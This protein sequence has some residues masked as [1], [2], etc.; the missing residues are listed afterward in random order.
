MKRSTRGTVIAGA[1]CLAS[2]IAA[3]TPLPDP[4]FDAAEGGFVPPD[5]D[6]YKQEVAVGKLL[7]KYAL[8]K[9]KCDQKAVI[10]LQLAYEPPG[11][12]KVPDVQA[13][14][15]ECQ[16]KV[17]LK[18]EVA[19]DKLLLKG[20]PACLNQAG[21]DAIK[22][23]LDTQ[24][25][26]LGA[27]VYCDG[28]AIAPDPETGLNIPDFKNEAVGEVA[29]AKV[30]TKVGRYGG[31]CYTLALKYAF[32][33][34]GVLPPD[35]LA[36]VDACFDKASLKGLEDMAKLDQAQKLPSCLPLATAE[37]LVGAT[38]DLSGQFNGETYCA[39]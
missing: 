12:P 7:T 33:L 14:W 10:A 13:D 5:S 28:D 15:D 37:A 9:T 6:V 20:T 32:K 17:L 3:A 19:R 11:A 25:G 2:G 36:K 26:L 8:S 34:G 38:V 35:I 30:L 39:E 22:G 1:I 29:A 4:P 21:I 31:K 27:V 16:A 18:Y 23:Q 24:I